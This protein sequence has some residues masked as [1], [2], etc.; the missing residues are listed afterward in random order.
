MLGRLRACTQ[1]PLGVSPHASR[2]AAEVGPLP[3]PSLPPRPHLRQLVT[4]SSS[5]GR[6]RP[7]TASSQHPN[8]GCTMVQS[9]STGSCSERDPGALSPQPSPLPPSSCMP[10]LGPD[11]C[12]G[13]EPRAPTS[14]TLQ[15]QGHCVERNAP[16]HPLHG[17][18]LG[19]NQRLSL[20]A[21]GVIMF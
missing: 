13:R 3:S 16:I 14:S 17:C 12:R 4:G 7:W 9:P 21:R 11:C 20:P 10:P 8:P 2:E 1:W 5:W 15:G 6:K 18:A 19:W